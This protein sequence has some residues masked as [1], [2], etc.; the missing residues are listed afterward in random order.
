MR[1]SFSEAK[2]I[3]LSLSL[4]C[5]VLCLGFITVSVA[6][7]ICALDYY[8]VSVPWRC[9][10]LYKVYIFNLERISKSRSAVDPYRRPK[11]FHSQ[12]TVATSILCRGFM[13]CFRGL[14]DLCPGLSYCFSAVEVYCVVL[15]SVVNCFWCVGEK[16][17]NSRASQAT[18]HWATQRSDWPTHHLPPPSVSL[19]LPALRLNII[20]LRTFFF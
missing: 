19:P 3:P 2:T 18:R 4:S 12:L 5:H 1:C 15:V 17:R 20:A 6:W 8:T 7:M 9:T 11:L 14:D 16:I 10:V 13:H